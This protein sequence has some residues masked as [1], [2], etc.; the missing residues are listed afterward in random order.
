MRPTKK[1]KVAIA[2]ATPKVASSTK[3]ILAFGTV[4]K[5]QINPPRDD[6]KNG[7]DGVADVVKK[8]STKCGSNGDNAK[9]RKSDTIEEESGVPD[10]SAEAASIVLSR[11]LRKSTRQLDAS[12]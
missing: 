7:T 5:P 2:T 11:P 1:R 10:E 8:D 6:K 3:G 4:S 12:S 9:K